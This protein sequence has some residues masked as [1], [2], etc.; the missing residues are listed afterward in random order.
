MAGPNVVESE[1]HCL[2]LARQIKSVTDSLNLKLVFKA[3]FDKAN[4]TSATSFR[5]PGLNEGLRC[6]A[7]ASNTELS[8]CHSTHQ[9][10]IE[11]WCRTA[12]IEQKS[13]GHY[14]IQRAVFFGYIA[15]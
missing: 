14:S 1:E 9:A 11:T 2:K 4:R 10:S 12:C 3:S 6:A 13:I 15:A 8:I 7:A 5:G